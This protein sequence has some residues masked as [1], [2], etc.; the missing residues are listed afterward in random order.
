MAKKAAASKTTA[1]TTTVDSVVSAVNKAFQDAQRNTEDVVE[2][3]VRFSR[4][5]AHVSIGAPFVVQQRIA[6]RNFEVVDYR[7]F[8]D[9]AKA[10]GS[11]RVGELQELVEPMTAR[12]TEVVDPITERI[13]AQLPTQ[14][15]TTL[16]DNRR[17]MRDLLNA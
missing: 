13:E 12:V 2:G 11:E 1:P 7:T 16:Q 17:R 9:E 6:G 15:R 5:A 4:D 14:V 8:L 10:E 3:A